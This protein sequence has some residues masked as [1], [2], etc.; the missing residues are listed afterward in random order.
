MKT[1]ILEFSGWN[2][3]LKLVTFFN[4]WI[5]FASAT[6]AF[7]LP[8][9]V[10]TEG[11]T[12]AAVILMGVIM[13]I[14]SLMGW[15]LG[16]IFDKKGI[17]VFGYGLAGLAMLLL[18][19]AFAKSYAIQVLIGFLFGIIIE[20]LWVGSEKL[21][22][23]YA[24]ADHFGRVD[25]IARSI[26][27]MGSLAGP[28]IAGIAIDAFGAHIAYGGLAV[29]MAALAASFGFAMKYANKK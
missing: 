13:T 17:R 16:K 22:T 6:V 2:G 20:L 1:L 9:Q 15:G 5:S 25:G 29:L 12:F 3:K 19:L 8:I 24:D 14:P 21:M 10:Y 18:C 26:G 7:F 4:F 28:L 27:D 11:S 23:V